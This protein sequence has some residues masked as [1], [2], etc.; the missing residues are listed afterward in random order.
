M[1]VFAGDPVLAADV[2]E[3]LNRRVG[4]FEGTSDLTA[5]SGTTEKVLDTLTVT[6]K[7]S[8]RYLISGYMPAVGSVTSDRFL[9]RIRAGTT[10]AGSQLTYARH[11]VPLLNSVD[12]SSPQCDFVPPSDGSYSFCTT[13]QRDNGTGTYTAKG[14]ASQPRYLR[15]DLATTA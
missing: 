8:R 14:A 12:T 10:I 3:A 7:G 13:A 11:N 5:T 15:V 2:N 4:N 9:I 1:T 6:L